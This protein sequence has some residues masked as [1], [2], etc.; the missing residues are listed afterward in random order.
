MKRTSSQITILT[1]DPSFAAWGWAVLT[2]DGKI[3]KTGC[4]KTAPQSKKL[5][6]RKGDDRVRRTQEICQEL[7]RIIKEYNVWLIVSELPHGSQNAQAAIMMGVVVGI[8]QTLSCA[9]GISIEWFSEADAKKAILNKKSATKSEM[10][11][12]ITAL[13]DVPWTG[14]N[15]KDE[16]VADCLSIFHVAKE[17]SSALQLLMRTAPSNF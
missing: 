17:Q 12:A 5:R 11:E 10:I 7:L 3:V 13:Y 14:V 2:P 8:L 1:N 15:Y 4:I 16:A 6:I 9:S